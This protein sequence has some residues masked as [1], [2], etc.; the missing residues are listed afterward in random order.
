MEKLLERFKKLSIDNQL[1]NL[2]NLDNK[3]IAKIYL[4]LESDNQLKILDKMDMKKKIE[5][6]SLLPKHN[7]CTF[8]QKEELF[9]S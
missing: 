6:L 3:F 9:W 8:P 2:Y 7:D 4:R 5:I 1:K